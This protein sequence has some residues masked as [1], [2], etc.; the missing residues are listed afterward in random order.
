MGPALSRQ[1]ATVSVP[2]AYTKQPCS[3][4]EGGAEQT[5]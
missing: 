3:A 5:H 2:T 1:L 4:E